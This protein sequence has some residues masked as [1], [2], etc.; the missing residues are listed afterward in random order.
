MKKAQ[1]EIFSSNKESKKVTF[2]EL[3]KRC[4]S[5]KSVHA[6][7]KFSDSV[8]EKE[9][10]SFN[11]SINNQDKNI[12]LSVLAI[13]SFIVYSSFM[14]FNKFCGTVIVLTLINFVTF[15][16]KIIPRPERIR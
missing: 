3:S 1:S 11:V 14:G 8:F 10:V 4:K 2:P 15:N 12:Y 13:R 7:S 6:F 16:I 5:Y 9:I